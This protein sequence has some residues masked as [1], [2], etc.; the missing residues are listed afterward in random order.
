MDS[1]LAKT[2]ADPSL[3]VLEITENLLIEKLGEVRGKMERLK[4]TGINI[5]L[6]DFGTGYSSLHY[7]NQLPLDYL[8]LD[9][10]FVSRLFESKKE[11]RL[12]KTIINMSIEL[13]LD[14]IVEGVETTKQLDWLNKVG[15]GKV[16]GFLIS[17][18]VPWEGVKN[19]MG[20][21]G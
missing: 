1:F 5:A 12:L 17:K 14:I 10:S 20:G 16:Q 21:E 15:C 8:K 18:P 7:I 19:L 11:Q 13:E 4:K 2:G 9:K 6:D 3:F